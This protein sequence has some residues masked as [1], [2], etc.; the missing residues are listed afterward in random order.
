MSTSHRKFQ[1]EEAIGKT[2]DVQAARRLMTYL[3]PC[4]RSLI[5][6]LALTLGINIL[7]IIQPKLT[8]Y[9]IDWYI[10]PRNASGLKWIGLIYL[11]V[12]LV[13]F[14]FSYVQEILVENVG[15]TVMYNLRSELFA[16]LQRQDVAYYDHTPVGRLMT[17]LTADVDALHELFTSGVINILGD[18]IMIFAIISMMLWLDWHL[19][20]IT[21]TTVPILFA[22]TTW[23]RR[24]SRKGYDR[25]RTRLAR[26]NSFLHEHLSGV[27]TVQLFNAQFQSLKKFRHI[28]D[29]HR[30][31]NIETIIYYALFYP[32]VDFICTLGIAFIILYGGWRVMQHVDSRS[33]LS[34]GALVAFIQYYQ[35]LFQPIRDLS[36]KYN[37]LQS[38]IV[39][40]H[41]IF[42]TLDLPVLVEDTKRSKRSGHAEGRIV[43]E[44]VWFAYKDNHW[45]LRDVSFTIEPGQVVAFVGH[46]GAGKTTIMNLLMRFYDVQRGRILLDGV[47]VRDWDL[48][49]L[50]RNFAVV[51]QDV[52]MFSGTLGNNI[53]LGRS[54]ITEEQVIRA[55]ESVQADRFI[56]RLRDGYETE[57]RERGAGLSVG[58]KQLISFARALAS[59]P[60]LLLLDEATSSIDAETERLVQEAIECVMRN[61]TSLVV[62][63]RLSTIQRADHIIVMHNGEVREQGTHRQL[64][65]ECGIYWKLHQL[66]YLNNSYPEL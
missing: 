23:F 8:H 3:K 56:K 20:L 1:E 39:S 37:V 46:T 42:E 28:N 35:Q 31:A 13:T 14:G 33:L 27:Q 38:A 26:I 6:A 63:H 30:R 59:N 58:Q 12:L 54:D 49:T 22:V 11:G 51:L 32:L 65:N 47:D 66:Q 50:R 43:F 9:A 16:K 29:E 17:R 55:A 2:S 60:T 45:V 61:R 36:E 19:T 15:R 64:L 52:F 41:R 53:R 48:Q 57:V 62:A 44:N 18:V 7:R 34:V 10:I 40:S 21:L 25:V 5:P 4:L 24:R